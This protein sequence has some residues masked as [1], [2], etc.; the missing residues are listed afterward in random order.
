MNDKDN[1]NQESINK[2]KSWNTNDFNKYLDYCYKTVLDYKNWRRIY[3]E[4]NIGFTSFFSLA[5]NFLLEFLI[6]G[7]CAK[8]ILICG[9]LGLLGSTLINIWYNLMKHSTK[10]TKL[11]WYH[12]RDHFNKIKKD[13]NIKKEK[14]NYDIFRDYYNNIKDPNKLKNEEDFIHLYNLFKFQSNYYNLLAHTR[15]FTLI[16]LSIFIISFCISLIVPY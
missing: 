14:I 6:A 8:K 3:L 2:N 15:R 7:E 4:L 1:N 5:I 11:T 12:Y 16:S 10:N 9:F 13:M